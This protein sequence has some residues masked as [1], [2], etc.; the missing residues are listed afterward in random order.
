MIDAL[1]ARPLAVEFRGETVRLRRPTIGDLVAA[2]DVQ[3][4]GENMAAWYVATHVLDSDGAQMYT[5]DVA[6]RLSAPA[7]IALARLIEPLY[8]EGLD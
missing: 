5:L 3:S 6:K 7:V 2:I 4:R 1:L 8:S